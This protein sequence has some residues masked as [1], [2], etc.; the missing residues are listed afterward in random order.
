MFY[1]ST[2]MHEWGVRLRKVLLLM[3]SIYLLFGHGQHSSPLRAQL[4]EDD[5][6]N[7]L[8]QEEDAQERPGMGS[9]SCL[10]PTRARDLHLWL[11]LSDDLADFL[12]GL[13][14]H[15]SCSHYVE[16]LLPSERIVGIRTCEHCA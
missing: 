16:A 9:A 4:Q 11:D 5:L 1:K 15:M 10:N 8:C 2:S 14:A 3:V 7:V 13:I 6:H 12:A